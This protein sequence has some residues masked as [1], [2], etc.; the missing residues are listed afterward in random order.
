MKITKTIIIIL[1]LLLAFNCAHKKSADK[2]DLTARFEKGKEYYEK[3]KYN[4][5]KVEFDFITMKSRGTQL[6][7][8]AQ[9]YLG[10][11]LFKQE[12]YIESSVEFARYIRL[13]RDPEKVEL[14]R[15]RMCECALN[16]S[17]EYQKDQSGSTRALDEFQAFIEDYPESKY[18]KE[19]GLSIESVRNKLAK[20]E[21]ETA[22]LYL[23]LEEYEGALIYFQSVL[24]LYYDTQYAD[25]S[26][27]GIV[28]TYILN[29]KREKAELYLLE[30]QYNFASPEKY[31]EAQT[32]LTNTKAGKLTMSE[33]MRLYK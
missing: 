30:N 32:I 20:K 13:S 29:N 21:Y 7:V 19:A 6:A 8:N 25:D 33:Y 24:N 5:A 14:A 4:K 12:K 2:E 28:F 15:F 23:K 22:R 9:Y 17:M 27:I 10:E 11:L 3:E 26:R 18:V 1:T 31:R 16:S